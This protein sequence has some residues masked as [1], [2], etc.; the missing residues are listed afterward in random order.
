MEPQT[1]LRLALLKQEAF[2]KSK[3]FQMAY[4]QLLK[5]VKNSPDIIEGLVNAGFPLYQ[6]LLMMDLLIESEEKT[7]DNMLEKLTIFTDNRVKN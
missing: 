1:K 2:N 5:D 3:H 4:E 6:V 7:A